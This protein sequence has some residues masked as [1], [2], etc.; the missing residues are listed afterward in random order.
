MKKRII[1]GAELQNSTFMS[2][3]EMARVVSLSD[4]SILKI[5]DPSMLGFMGLIGIDMEKKINDAKPIAGSP[6]I[7]VPTAAAYS[8]NGTF[9]GYTVNRARGIDYNTHDDRFTIARR[10]DLHMYAKEHDRAEAVLRRNPN[11]VFPDFCTCDNMFIDEAGNF[12]FIDYDGLQVGPHRSL[13]FSTS[14]GDAGLYFSDPKYC[15]N[16]HFTKELDKKSS[17]VLYFLTAFNVD[18]NKVGMVNPVTGTA[19][20]LDDLF[21]AIGLDDPDLC[22]KVWKTFQRN[23]HNEFLGDTVYD[24]AEKYDMHVLSK[25]NDCYLKVLTKKR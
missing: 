9:M 14:L 4:G 20:T 11:I 21:Y 2:Q 25:R 15:R 8:Q 19:V 23:Q 6:E 5:F 7:L 24:I 1:Y 13:S 17:I 22:H 10:E 16:G 12:Q 18:L 3:S